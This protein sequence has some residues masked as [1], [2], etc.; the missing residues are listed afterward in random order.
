MNLAKSFSK[1][2]FLWIFFIMLIIAL[3]FSISGCLGWQIIFS[4]LPVNVLSNAANKSIELK[5]GLDQVLPVLNLIN[6]YFI[7]GTLFIFF[8]FT[9]I[10]WLILRNVF[11]RLIE[12]AG[13]PLDHTNR[14]VN[15]PP[16]DKKLSLNLRFKNLPVPG[17]YEPQPADK[18]E[19]VEI[20]QRLYL[21]LLSVLQRE[22]RLM[23]FIAED[24]NKYDDFQIGAAARNIHESCKKILQKFLKP[25]AIIDKMEGD[26]ITV[27]SGFDSNTIKLIGNINGEPPFHGILRH[28]GWQ[29]T[30]LELP[31][32]TSGQ[33]PR[34]ISPAE[35]EIS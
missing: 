32:L 5:T 31:T 8:S 6:R 13:L 15:A 26:Q 16:S 10:L 19:N 33:N 22:G 21:H 18:K 27:S 17:E 9:L 2:I 24:L 23:D 25:T 30:R 12:K 29:A 7:F 14:I 35:V 4:R 11:I 34:I 3:I 28:K 20:N 1:K